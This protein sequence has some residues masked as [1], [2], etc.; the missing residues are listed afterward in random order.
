MAVWKFRGQDLCQVAN[1]GQYAVEDLYDDGWFRLSHEDPRILVRV[2]RPWTPKWPDVRKVGLGVWVWGLTSQD[3]ENRLLALRGLVAAGPGPLQHVLF[4]GWV[5]EMQ[6]ELTRMDVNTR[7]PMAAKVALEFQSVDEPFF[8]RI[9][10]TLFTEA[11]IT[12]T[13]SPYTVDFQHENPGL[14]DRGMRIRFYGPATNPTI[15]NLTADPDLGVYL[16]YLGTLATTGDFIEFNVRTFQATLN[17][18]AVVSETN[19][20]HSG[21]RYWFLL[22]TGMNN[23]RFGAEDTGGKVEIYQNPPF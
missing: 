8:R 14:E 16:G 9:D 23:L 18:S 11:T 21:D 17:G 12:A 19:I 15:W 6:A 10:T 4:N 7:G 5:L 13:S 2:G 3:F 1:G 20:V 22:K